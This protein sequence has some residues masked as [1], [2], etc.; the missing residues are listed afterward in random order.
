M[1]GV[2]SFSVSGQAPVVIG[3]RAGTQYVEYMVS[4]ITEMYEVADLDDEVAE[5]SGTMDPYTLL[6]R[7][8]SQKKKFNRYIIRFEGFLKRV[9][10]K[11]L[12]LAKYYYSEATFVASVGSSE[13]INIEEFKGTPESSLNFSVEAQSED[14]A[15]KLGRQ[16]SI[17][18]VLQ[19]VGG[20]LPQ[21]AVGKLI[22][23]MPYANVKDAFSD[24]TLDYETATND[25]LAL[26]RGQMPQMN[27][28]DKHE[29]FVARAS[30][31]TRAPD[32]MFMPDFIKQ[33]Y[34]LYIQQ[35]MEMIREQKEALQREE[36]GFIPDG[37]ALVGV[38]LYVSD[39]Q[40]PTRPSKRAKI[41]QYAVE[42]LIEKLK[43]QGMFKERVTAVIP[44]EVL[45]QNSIEQS[46]GQ[47]APEDGLLSMLN[48][49]SIN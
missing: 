2:R 46:I 36:A 37:G 5:N 32:F 9:C 41:P 23:E 24:E 49:M 33:N 13:R 26:D 7:A 35:H 20:N 6:Y 14:V 8:A 18:H 31:R 40:D 16:L 3:G 30:A 19:Y 45:A 15:T 42:W 4:Q 28:Y 34:D 38:D 47:M 39:P 48:N 21:G 10:R 11:A 17:N 12:K 22:A 1:P 44:E 25:L 43:D 29:Y 27:P